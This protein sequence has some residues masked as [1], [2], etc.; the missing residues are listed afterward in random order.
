MFSGGLAIV[1]PGTSLATRLGAGVCEKICSVVWA[2]VRVN[3]SDITEEALRDAA[4]HLHVV[5]FFNKLNCL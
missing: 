1:A 4:T 5:D 2:R 3:A